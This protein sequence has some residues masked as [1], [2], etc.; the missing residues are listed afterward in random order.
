[1]TIEKTVEMKFKDEVTKRHDIIFESNR[2][3]A[4]LKMNCNDIIT[5]VKNE[6]ILLHLTE[7][8]K[9]TVLEQESIQIIVGQRRKNFRLFE[10]ILN[11][12]PV[13]YIEFINALRSNDMY[14]ELANQIEQSKDS[15]V[16]TP[17]EINIEIDDLYNDKIPE[18]VRNLHDNHIQDWN[19]KDNMII[20]TQ[21]FRNI[22]EQL[23]D[24]NCVVVVGSQGNGKS[25]MLQHIALIKCNNEAYDII[26]IVMEPKNIIQFYN[27]NRNQIFVVDDLC[28][29]ERVNSQHIDI[30]GLDIEKV[31]KIIN[32]GSLPGVDRHER[33]R[34]KTKIL[35][36][37]NENIYND[38]SFRSLQ[39]TLKPYVCLLSK[40][41]LSEKERTD[42][43]KKYLPNGVN[44]FQYINRKEIEI[45]LLCKLAEGKTYDEIRAMFSHPVKYI[46]NYLNELKEKNNH[47]F[48]IITLCTLFD[49]TF[50][51]EW[52]KSDS[53]PEKVKFAAEEIGLNLKKDSTIKRMQ[54]EFLK[55]DLL[56]FSR[57]G[58]TYHL[59]H[60]EIHNIAAVICGNVFT[61][62][63][64]KYSSGSFIAQRFR[65]ES[66]NE[67]RD[68]AVILYPKYHKRYFDRLL[69]DLEKGDTYS[70]FHNIQLK[71]SEYR[72]KF[73][74][75]CKD[76]KQKFM[77]ILSQLKKNTKEATSNESADDYDC[78][79]CNIY[80]N[81]HKIGIPL[82]ESAWEGH[83]DVV[84]MLL[85]EMDCDINETDAFGRTALFVA[86]ARGHLNVVKELL[87]NH[88]AD[89]SLC[90][91]KKRTPLYSACEEGYID[92]ARILI[93]KGANILAKDI[94]GC[95]SFLKA[96]LYGHKKIAKILLEK[97][98]D[99]RE[100]MR[101]RD[102]SGRTPIIAAA[103]NDQ[104]NIISFLLDEGA[105]VNDADSK[106]IT[107][108]YVASLRNC[109]ET[110][111]KLLDHDADMFKLDNDGC[112]ALFVA[113]RNGSFKAV[114]KLVTKDKAMI[115][116]CDWHKR[117]PFYIA[118]KEGHKDVVQILLKEGVDAVS[119][120]EDEKSPLY[121][122]SENGH[123]TV[124][125]KLLEVNVDVNK[126]DRQ[127]RSPLHVACKMGHIE[128]VRLLHSK[129]ADLS[130]CDRWGGSPFFIACREG[131]IDIV[132]F[133][134]DKCVYVNTCDNNGNS[135]LYVA[136][137]EGHLYIVIF[138][139]QKGAN[140]KYRN[141]NGRLA[142]HAA[143][144]GG[145]K[146]IIK[147]LINYDSPFTPDID[148]Q[149]PA[150]L[151]RR[152]RLLSVAEMM[153]DDFNAY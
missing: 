115:S 88:K 136:C 138:L 27:P 86:S 126:C 41:P 35:I 3:K 141:N 40:Y 153:E 1:M 5:T 105:N 31:I 151:A 127:G 7:Q 91:N 26:P 32:D 23:L 64:I 48:C 11:H 111:S 139:L 71:E 62:C 25:S 55:T 121:V 14:A 93:E 77:E 150:A 82:I 108:L 39:I 66:K 116:K 109:S 30:W 51:S 87:Q 33:V 89:V 8:E 146:K 54:E 148:G 4:A 100:E 20:E 63:F 42:M 83:A 103:Q 47:R 69:L 59:I 112:S 149:T 118:C 131:Y 152:N 37:C 10:I 29:K 46:K 128:I 96:C 12:D 34:R 53:M 72:D 61:E 145:Y 107:P 79:K 28:G 92:I 2:C 101:K 84:N 123:L 124:V 95:S 137:E 144:S 98:T 117:T 68:K 15:M 58:T 129:G 147:I 21:A 52:L 142:I 13:P 44:T 110:V 65:M 43:L 57:T 125:E 22:M 50:K 74:D 45:P 56:Y 75:Y 130:H 104:C 94:H 122:S 19:S 135:P 60:E 120:D 90:D 67:V 81:D 114:E 119:C 24:K 6:D 49:N 18:E 38:P 80:F 76:R 36:S 102:N 132:K 113:C 17:E 85:D 16:K 134:V 70:S 133:L 143:S 73:C 99:G 106:G 140:I 9:L 78:L 97:S